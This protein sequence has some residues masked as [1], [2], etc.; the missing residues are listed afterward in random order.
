MSSSNAN[1]Q[2]STSKGYT[3]EKNFAF[4]IHK[5]SINPEKTFQ[6]ISQHPGLVCGMPNCMND[7]PLVRIRDLVPNVI[8]NI[9]CF[10]YEFDNYVTLVLN[11]I[12]IRVDPMAGDFTYF[13]M[14][15]GKK[16]V[17]MI[18]RGRNF[19]CFCKESCTECS[20]STKIS[21]CECLAECRIITFD[22]DFTLKELKSYSE[23]ITDDET[24]D[25]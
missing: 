25:I 15:N 20:C 6:K 21:P 17:D 9:V 23:S 3:Y 5:I 10:H 7:K 18:P 19:Q 16:V 11:N 13:I 4:L 22:L 24:Y 8:Y 14:Y 1:S 12:M 2:N